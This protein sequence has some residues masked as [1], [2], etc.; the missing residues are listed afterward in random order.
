M[1]A[2]LIII[3]LMPVSYAAGYFTANTPSH[4]YDR[5]AMD[6]LV[7]DL[8]FTADFYIDANEATND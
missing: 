3:S 1:K 4:N 2:L 7:T 8:Q 6:R 5:V